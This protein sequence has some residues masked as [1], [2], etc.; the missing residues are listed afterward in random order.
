[1]PYRPGVLSP[2]A[3]SFGIGSTGAHNPVGGQILGG[4]SP[5]DFDFG[6][7]FTDAYAAKSANSVIGTPVSG[8]SPTDGLYAGAQIEPLDKAKLGLAAGSALLNGFLGMRQY[9]LAKDQLA[10][11]KEAFKT[12][13]ANQKK[14]VNARIEDRA[15]ARHAANPNAYEDPTS[16]VARNRV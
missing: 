3:F 6:N 9:G 14:L 12:N 10:F 15:R 8:G 5:T 11:Q 1:M 16:Y 2:E 7:S 13:L 4:Y